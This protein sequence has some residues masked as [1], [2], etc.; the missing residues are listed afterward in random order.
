MSNSAVQRRVAD[1]TAAG[2]NPAL[3]FT[4]GSEASTPT[5][6]PARVEPT[7]KPDWIDLTSKQLAM[8]Q[9]KNVDAQTRAK[10]AEASILEADVP[11]ASASARARADLAQEQL[12]KIGSEIANL[13]VLNSLNQVRWD[14]AELDYDQRQ[15]LFPLQEQAQK[16]LNE[17]TKLQ[18]EGQTINQLKSRW[19]TYLLQLGSKEAEAAARFWK[20]APAAKWLMMIRQLA[21]GGPGK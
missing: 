1:I 7:F 17:A 4:T 9:I 18:N 6:S 21:G 13:N 14:I 10:N 19:E 20:D 16:L 11:Y 12:R 15:K 2:G 8:A 3:A 5:V